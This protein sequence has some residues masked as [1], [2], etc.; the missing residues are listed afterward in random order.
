[1]EKKLVI[2]FMLDFLSVHFVNNMHISVP[3]LKE[4]KLKKKHQDKLVSIDV[5][6]KLQLNSQKKNYQKTEKI[7]CRRI[8]C[9]RT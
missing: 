6:M 5:L 8:K 4:K 2:S 9:F 3:S 7:T 1:M